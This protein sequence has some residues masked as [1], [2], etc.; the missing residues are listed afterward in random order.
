MK[1]LSLPKIT[2]ENKNYSQPKKKHVFTNPFSSLL[3]K[4]KLKKLV[5]DSDESKKN[6]G[7]YLLTEEIKE[8]KNKFNDSIRSFLQKEEINY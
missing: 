1:K 3:K 7:K 8:P 5:L 4:Y 2:K 6:E